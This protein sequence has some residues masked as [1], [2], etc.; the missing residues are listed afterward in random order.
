MG[1]IKSIKVNN[2][3]NIKSFTFTVNQQGITTIE[4]DNNLG[5]S[6]LLN[7]TNWFFTDNIFT[8]KWGSGENDISSI[9]PITQIKGEYVSVAVE[10]ESGIVFEKRYTTAWDVRTG[11]VK[12]HTTEGLIN[13]TACKSLKMWYDELYKEINYTT[14][15]NGFKE[16]N[17]FTDPLYALQKMDAKDLRNLLQQLGCNITNDEVFQNLKDLDTTF[18]E[19]EQEKYRGNF[20]DMRTD[21]KRKVQ[22]DKESLKVLESQLALYNECPEVY[23]DEKLKEINKQIEELNKKYYSISNADLE[24]QIHEKETALR[25]AQYEKEEIKQ[26]FKMQKF[27]D[28]ARLISSINNEKDRIE[29]LKKQGN[30][31][32]IEEINHKVREIEIASQ[33]LMSLNNQ[34]T[35]IETALK[36]SSENGKRYIV[37]QRETAARLNALLTETYKDFI[38]CPK[39]QHQF[40]LDET[41]AQMW[42]QNHKRDIEYNNKLIE[43]YKEKVQNELK[44]LTVLKQQLKDCDAS[45]TSA[46][47]TLNELQAAKADLESKLTLNEVNIDTTLLEK[48]E[49]DFEKINNSKADTTAIDKTIN[50]LWDEIVNL[51]DNK[52]TFLKTEREN[53]EVT[54]EELETAQQEEELKRYKVSCKNKLLS[55]HKEVIEQLNNHEKQLLTINEFIHKSIELCNQKAKAITGFD[56]VMLEETLSETIKEVCYL[57]VDGVPFKDVNTSRKLIIGTQ[58]IKRV[59]EILNAKNN[60]PI[61]ADKLETVSQNTLT[62]Y[63]NVFSD[64]QFI[65]TRVTNGKEL[66]VTW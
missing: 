40:I 63:N 35:G 29:K 28:S 21:Y 52:E 38:T 12:G 66:K 4:G 50:D 60:L 43:S 8:D 33:N 26:K 1:K 36:Q 56:F 30:S 47:N 64:I 15:L 11:K 24:K 62:N 42:E 9:V 32:L 45:Y 17:L 18:M 22:A 37:E 10:F 39:C 27:N 14:K 3:R 25:Q 65:T 2:F 54:K 16:L 51:K 31:S 58:F 6:N 55:E 57:S 49:A 44:T 23:N 5:K 34:K 41:K 7:A 61:M 59:K 20:Y 46:L 13:N 19:I 53:L 48:M